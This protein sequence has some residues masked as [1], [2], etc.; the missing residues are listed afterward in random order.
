MKS[1]SGLMVE[2][3]NNSQLLRESREVP[4]TVK[5]SEW[6]VLEKPERFARAYEFPNSPDSLSFFVEELLQF[7]EK[8]GHHSKITIEK[9]KVTVEVY[10]HGIDRITDLDKEFAREA[11]LIF[12]D[13]KEL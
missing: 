1:V 2:Y 3:F 5:K 7:Q 6:S 4:I 8:L 13:S 11:D 10:T 9:D 12:R